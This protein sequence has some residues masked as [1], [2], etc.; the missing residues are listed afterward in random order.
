MKYKFPDYTWSWWPRR[1]DSRCFGPASTKHR[2]GH[3]LP[4]DRQRRQPVVPTETCVHASSKKIVIIIIMLVTNSQI[5][6]TSIRNSLENK[7]IESKA[8]WIP[9][10]K[11]CILNC[12]IN[13][14]EYFPSWE[15]CYMTSHDCKRVSFFSSFGMTMCLHKG[16]NPCSL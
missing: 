6:R 2:H 10:Y 16:K 12:A 14:L 15:L 5:T 7:R 4:R 3:H 11:F 1:N 8:T 9:F 13:I